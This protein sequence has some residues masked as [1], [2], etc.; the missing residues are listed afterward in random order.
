MSLIDSSLASHRQI[1]D[2]I[3][4]S[5]DIDMIALVCDCYKILV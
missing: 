2:I 4:I 1:L 3:D 5:Y